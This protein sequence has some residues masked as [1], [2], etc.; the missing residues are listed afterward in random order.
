MF[1]LGKKKNK[2]D[3]IATQD[4]TV[5]D[6]DN[7]I[8]LAQNYDMPWTALAQLNNIEPPYVLTPGTTVRVPA[9]PA[10]ADMPTDADEAAAPPSPI[11][12]IGTPQHYT[13]MPESSRDDSVAIPQHSDTIHDVS[14]SIAPQRKSSLQAATGAA[15]LSQQTV[16]SPDYSVQLPQRGAMPS[17]DSVATASAVDTPSPQITQ[18]H[19]ITPQS[20]TADNNPNRTILYAS[21]ESMIAQPASEPT[22][23]A[24]DIE[25]MRDDEAAYAEEMQRQQKRTSR[26]FGMT[27]FVIVLLLL[28]AAGLAYVYIVPQATKD[29]VSL[30]A[31]IHYNDAPTH[32]A[33]SSEEQPAQP[34]EDVQQEETA[35]EEQKN[36]NA[37]AEEPTETAATV[38]PSDVTVQVLNAGGPAGAAGTVTTLL[39][40]QSFTTR[41]AQNAKNTY[42][43]TVV[44]Y[45]ADKKDAATEVLKH[46]PATY[47]TPTVEESAD[48][49]TTYSAAVVVVIGAQK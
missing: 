8:S 26:W 18:R 29:K 25:W 33:Q 34:Q 12:V 19:P 46:L 16:P 21:P 5:R 1:G 10:E 9:T 35:T 43:G 37:T 31:L 13:T 44:Y 11:R 4:Y 48:V 42:T 24:I 3:A 30:D 14:P 2:A 45:A 38:T 22:T 27:I 17:D 41:T 40:K 47:G 32:D 7:I 6:G 36:D 28:A 39:Q 20:D 23:R 49:T 15:S